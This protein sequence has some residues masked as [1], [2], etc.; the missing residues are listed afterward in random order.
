MY[1]LLNVLGLKFLNP[2]TKVVYNIPRLSRSEIRTLNSRYKVFLTF[3]TMTKG[4]SLFSIFFPY[5]GKSFIL[6]N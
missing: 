1:H 4:L 5:F 6:V 3:R 2:R